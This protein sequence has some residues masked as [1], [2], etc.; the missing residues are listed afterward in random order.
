MKREHQA[1]AE[2]EIEAQ[3]EDFLFNITFYHC[4]VSES[5]RV[6]I[7]LPPGFR[8]GSVRGRGGYFITNNDYSALFFLKIKVMSSPEGAIE[9][10]RKHGM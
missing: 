6:R 4:C 5:A 9:M 2:A 3:G 1:K 7:N 10:L 8:F